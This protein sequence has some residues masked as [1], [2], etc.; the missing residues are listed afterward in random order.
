[1]TLDELL[2]SLPDAPPNPFIEAVALMSAEEMMDALAQ[3]VSLM[4]SSPSGEHDLHSRALMT[5]AAELL[6]DQEDDIERL[7]ATIE[8]IDNRGR[9][10]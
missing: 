2:A 7:E 1:M 5:R 6:R 10:I 9:D 3:Q 4:A 8:D